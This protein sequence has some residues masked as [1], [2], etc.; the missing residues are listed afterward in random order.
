MWTIDTPRAPAV[1]IDPDHDEKDSLG[2]DIPN[3]GEAY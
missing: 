1:I 2:V 3:L